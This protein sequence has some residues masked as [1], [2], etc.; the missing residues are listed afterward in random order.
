MSTER[1]PAKLEK[2]DAT[3]RY[4]FRK[5]NFDWETWNRKDLQPHG[6]AGLFVFIVGWAGAI[7]CMY[8][9]YFIGPIAALVG[10]GANLGLIVACGLT[11]ICYPPA[12]LLELKVVGR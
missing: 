11:L 7:L 2:D 3:F 1:N 5:G 4:I 10:N 9:T 6:V 8:Q 12:R